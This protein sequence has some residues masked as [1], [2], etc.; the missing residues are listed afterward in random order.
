MRSGGQILVIGKAEVRC[1]QLLISLT[2]LRMKNMGIMAILQIIN[3]DQQNISYRRLRVHFSAWPLK[4]E[5]NKPVTTYGLNYAF[6]PTPGVNT[7]EQ[8]RSLAPIIAIVPITAK[9][10]AELENSKSCL[11]ASAGQKLI[12]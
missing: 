7:D 6:N 9:R 5:T 8:L 4:V 2:T 12:C 10:Y 3:L 11:V 1:R